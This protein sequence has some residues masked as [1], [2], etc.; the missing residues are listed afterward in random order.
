MAEAK[1]SLPYKSRLGAK[2]VGKI[3]LRALTETGKLIWGKVEHKFLTTYCITC[4]P[5]LDLD[6]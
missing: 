3:S 5:I 6:V 1:M 2:Y 4:V